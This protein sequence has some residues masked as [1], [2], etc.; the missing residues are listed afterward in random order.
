M[1]AER[2][3]EGERGVVSSEAGFAARAEARTRVQAALFPCAVFA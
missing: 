2:L 1:R 3:R